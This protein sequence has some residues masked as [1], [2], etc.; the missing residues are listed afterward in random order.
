VESVVALGKTLEIQTVAEGVETADQRQYLT[1]IGCDFLQGFLLARPLAPS[2]AEA[3]LRS[4]GAAT[5]PVSARPT[6]PF[7][8]QDAG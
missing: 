2:D 5:N 1:D 3:R 6:G 8:L 7:L 4:S